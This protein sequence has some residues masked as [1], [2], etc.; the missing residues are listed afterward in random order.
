MQF[1]TSVLSE[2]KNKKF[3]IASPS[4]EIYGLINQITGASGKINLIDY[5]EISFTVAYGDNVQNWEHLKKF[6]TVYVEDVGWIQ[7]QEPAET[8]LS[9]IHILSMKLIAR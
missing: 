7:L 2:I 8:D 9:L 6:N 3:F 5:S 1:H 4:K